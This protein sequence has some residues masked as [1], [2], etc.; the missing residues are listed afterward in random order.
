MTPV[1]P[2]TPT[3]V[4]QQPTPI[5][6]LTPT[7][8][9]PTPIAVAL[10]IVESKFTEMAQAVKTSFAGVEGTAKVLNNY[11]AVLIP[12]DPNTSLGSSAL[13][14]RQGSES[15]HVKDPMLLA[16][17]T[18][19]FIASKQIEAGGKLPVGSKVDFY[20]ASKEK[21]EVAALMPS[22]LE[23][24][25]TLPDGRQIVVLTD[26]SKRVRAVYDVSTAKMF[27]FEDPQLKQLL[28][29]GGVQVD[30]TKDLADSG[31]ILAKDI[32]YVVVDGGTGEI[33]LQ[34]EPAAEV[35]NK[36]TVE[37]AQDALGNK[38]SLA[39]TAAESLRDYKKGEE[40]QVSVVKVS[41]QYKDRPVMFLGTD[42]ARAITEVCAKNG[43]VSKLNTHREAGSGGD[44][45][46]DFSVVKL[47]PGGIYRV[48]RVFDGA[49][50]RVKIE[51][52]VLIA[53]P[54]TNCVNGGTQNVVGL[55]RPDG[56]VVTFK[57]LGQLPEGMV[58]T[59][60]R[61]EA[62]VVDP[63]VQKPNLILGVNSNPTY[64]HKIVIY[65]PTLP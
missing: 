36:P 31:S 49:I 43:G 53:A 19:K 28:K 2:A 45:S 61:I 15:R 10:K 33:K 47:E 20:V 17:S 35:R 27:T 4:E 48:K 29:A 3:I 64:R 37:T 11:L 60:M 44:Y 59:I 34:N 41:W 55:N 38:Y 14:V 22:L 42:D 9:K 56:S 65:P 6:T 54:L 62:W 26:D 24:T 7:P 58:I 46:T 8:E 5:A 32:K 25:V 63:M 51:D 23:S 57:D 12:K 18:G 40:F 1:A 39:M 52:S 13:L 50:I 16:D 30:S 21:G